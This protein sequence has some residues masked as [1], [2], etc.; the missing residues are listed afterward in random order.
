MR[1]RL[2]NTEYM[3]VKEDGRRWD[4]L[5]GGKCGREGLTKAKDACKNLMGILFF[6]S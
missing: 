3:K 4:G 2:W 6:V 5:S 1:E